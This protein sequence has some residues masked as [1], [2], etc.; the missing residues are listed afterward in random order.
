MTPQKLSL[1][2]T[3]L[4]ITGCPHD[5]T[6]MMKDDRLNQYGAAIRWGLWETASEFQPPAQQGRL[7]LAYLK[8]IHVSSYDPIYRQEHQGSDILNQNVEIR[9]FHEQSGVEKIITDRQTWRYDHEK[10]QWF[11]QSGL[12]DFR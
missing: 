10:D 1:I 4:L 6:S 11:L 2:L 5:L 3:C 9:Y 12:P 8:S 7:D